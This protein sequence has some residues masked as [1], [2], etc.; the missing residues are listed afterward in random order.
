MVTFKLVD[1]SVFIVVILVLIVVVFK[2]E[3][4]AT[5]AFVIV[6]LNI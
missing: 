3:G 6:N 1:F 4:A 5:E 2:F